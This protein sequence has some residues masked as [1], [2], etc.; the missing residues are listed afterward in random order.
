MLE[1]ASVSKLLVLCNSSYANIA[2][3]IERTA[4]M[5]LLSMNNI[6]TY[7]VYGCIQICVWLMR[8]IECT[9]AIRSRL[10]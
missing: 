5:Q 3:H 6:N 1:S 4:D 7:M 8:N 2:Q 9:R 10:N